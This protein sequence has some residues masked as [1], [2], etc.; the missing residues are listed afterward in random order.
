MGEAFF[1][2]FKIQ[3]EFLVATRCFI[4]FTWRKRLVFAALQTAVWQPF[5]LTVLLFVVCFCFWAFFFLSFFFF[6][7]FF[8]IPFHHVSHCIL[9]I[10]CSDLFNIDF[11]GKGNTNKLTSAGLLP[12]VKVNHFNRYLQTCDQNIKKTFH[13]DSVLVNFKISSLDFSTEIQENRRIKIQPNLRQLIILTE[14]SDRIKY[15]L[16]ISRFRSKL[17]CQIPFFVNA[18]KY[19]IRYTFQFVVNI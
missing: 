3:V 14:Q 8:E 7:F 12:L 15:F 2:I 11:W 6:F 9:F 17:L 18:L 19:L 10:F 1:W 4:K 5:V 13:Q 16:S